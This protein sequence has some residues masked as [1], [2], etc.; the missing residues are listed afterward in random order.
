M[1]FLNASEMDE[2]P[3]TPPVPTCNCI[4]VL[5]TT[6]IRSPLLPYFRVYH[7]TDTWSESQKSP[8][9]HLVVNTFNNQWHHTSHEVKVKRKRLFGYVVSL[10]LPEMEYELFD[11]IVSWW[12]TNG[13][14]GDLLDECL[15]KIST[16]C[17]W[18]LL[19]S[20]QALHLYINHSL[21]PR[22]KTQFIWNK[23][24]NH[25]IISYHKPHVYFFEK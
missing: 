12:I 23:N 22:V 9:W 15:L 11:I 24:Y 8:Q 7:P 13:T 25:Q 4:L 16:Q 2:Y 10:C 6:L 3:S 18:F 1:I 17:F 21:K 14:T 5:T 19:A 20:L